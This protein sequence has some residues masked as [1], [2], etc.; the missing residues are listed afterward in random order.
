MC[1]KRNLQATL[2]TTLAAS[3]LSAC[4]GGGGYD[5]DPP[6]PPPAQQKQAPQIA[7]LQ[8]QSMNQDTSTPVLPFQVSDADS[9]ANALTVT[10]RSS[11]TSLIPEEGILLD[12]NAGSRTLQVTPAAEAIGEAT[13]TIRAVDPD[14]LSAERIVRITVNGVFVSFRTMTNEVFATAEDADERPMSGFTVT[15]DADD[16]PAAFDNLLQ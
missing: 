3:V 5:D 11:D 14:G 7:G 8:D 1:T 9:G 13:V 2:L 15:Q 10:A 4:G 16:D 6:A 12:G